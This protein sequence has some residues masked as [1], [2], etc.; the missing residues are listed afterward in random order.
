[1]AEGATLLHP[2]LGTN[3]SAHYVF[4]SAEAGTGETRTG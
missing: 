1:M 4:D 3:A 2:D